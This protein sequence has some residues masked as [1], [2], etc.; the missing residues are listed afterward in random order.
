MLLMVFADGPRADNGSKGV[1][2]DPLFVTHNS[3]YC[4]QALK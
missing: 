4:I 2:H 3:Y 1:T